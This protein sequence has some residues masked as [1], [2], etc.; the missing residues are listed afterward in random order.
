[1][2]P[3]SQCMQSIGSK[4]PAHG[5]FVVQFSYHY[6]LIGCFWGSQQNFGDFTWYLQKLIIFVMRTCTYAHKIMH[7]FEGGRIFFKKE[8]IWNSLH[9]T[10]L[11]NNPSIMIKH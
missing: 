2:K 6:Q 9:R 11:D 4:C 10:K 1:M 8:L 3:C 7:L 5:A